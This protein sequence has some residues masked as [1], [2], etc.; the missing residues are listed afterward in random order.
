MRRDKR[1][2]QTAVLGSADSEDP[3]VLPLEAIEL[4]AFRR[5][6]EHHSFWCGLLLGGCGGQL[7]TKL[8]TDRVCHFAH[9]PGG[10]GHRPLCGRSSRGVNSADHLYVKSATTAWLRSRGERADFD[11]A[12]PDGARIGSVVDIQLQHTALRVH[13]DS[14]VTPDWDH[15]GHEPVLG[16]SVPVDPDTLIRRWYVHRIRLDSQGTTRQ[17]QIGTEAFARPTE[18]FGLNECTVTQRGLS[19]PA[20]RRIV[21]SRTAPRWSPP[22]ARKETSPDARARALLSRLVDARV[23][24]NESS[25]DHVCWQI[26]QLEG[27]SES[28]RA[29]LDAA[30]AEAQVWR[31][32]LAESRRELFSSLERA[33]EAQDS[34]HVRSLLGK[35]KSSRSDGHTSSEQAV[36]DR[37][38]EHLAAAALVTQ[39]RI[40]AQAAAK[41]ASADAAS[42]VG[43]ILNNLRRGKYE[44]LGSEIEEL[45]RCARIAGGQLTIHHKRQIA[46]WKQRH[47][48]ASYEQDKQPRDSTR[49]GKITP[50]PAT[51]PVLRRYWIHR[52]CPICLSAAS[53]ECLDNDGRGKWTWRPSPHEER[54]K[55]PP[56]A[57]QTRGT[58]QEV[59]QNARRRRGSAPEAKPVKR[60]PR[61]SQESTTAPS[62]TVKD[63]V[64]PDCAATPGYHCKPR[65]SHPHPERA[66]Q[67]QLRWPGN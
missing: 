63:I 3:L 60:E 24:R 47:H 30:V 10:E 7:T 4:D 62:W 55:L 41:T 67:F 61:T 52:E 15:E 58:P 14:E 22:R 21:E 35:I 36:V 26:A 56:K 19:T 37:A 34:Q 6:H 5:R 9:N 49:Q 28:V 45:D 59:G 20:V 66:R 18:W 40:Q 57:V 39:R 33:L 12:R 32:E 11:F 42:S 25:A 43:R 44:D 46:Q 31:E 27:V 17:V 13:L 50:P 23:F 38:A 53:K 29:A 65:S 2:I 64:C 54:V 16:V 1:Q 48:S 51:K 8:Y